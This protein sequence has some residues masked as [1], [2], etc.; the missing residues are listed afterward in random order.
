MNLGLKSNSRFMKWRM[1]VWILEHIVGQTP[2]LNLQFN[3][4]R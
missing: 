1:E 3:M 2:S 4:I